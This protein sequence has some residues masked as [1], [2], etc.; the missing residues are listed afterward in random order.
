MRTMKTSLLRAAGASW[1]LT[2]CGAALG[3]GSTIA[4]L[5]PKDAAF[6]FGV[7]NFAAAKASFD[8]TGF[9]KI[10][11]DPKV[12]AFIE[13]HAKKEMEDLAKSFEDAG[14]KMDEIEAPTGPAGAAT[15]MIWNATDKR[16]DARSMAFGDWGEKADATAKQVQDAI[17]R[18]EEKKTLTVKEDEYN[19]TKIWVI[20][21][22]KQPDAAKPKGAEDGAGEPEMEDAADGMGFEGEEGHDPFEMK[23]LVYARSGNHL[24][25]ASDIQTMESTLDRLAGK[26]GDSVGDSAEFSGVMA[27]LEKPQGYAVFL[28]GPLFTLLNTLTEQA[29][30]GTEGV[31]MMLA[32]EPA[33]STAMTAFGVAG[34]KAAG[35]GI[36]FDTESAMGEQTFAVLCPE[37]KGIMTLFAGAD[38]KFTAPSFVNADSGAVTLLQF[39]FSDLLSTITESARGLPPEVGDSLVQNVQQAQVMAGPILNNLGPQVWISNSYSKPLSATSSQPLFAIAC[40]DPAQF[41][42]ALQNLGGMLPIQSRDFQGN[43]LWSLSGGLPVPGAADYAMGVGFGHVFIGSTATVENAMRQAGAPDAAGLSKEARFN[44]AVRTIGGSGLAFGYTDVRQALEYAKWT[45]DNPEKVVEA[46]MSSMFGNDPDAEAY[47][48]EMIEEAKKNQPE[49][50][51]EIP[52][53]VAARELGDTVFEFHIVPEGFKGR[54][55]WLRPTK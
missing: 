32:D 55:L 1:L 17:D 42:Q 8:K 12:K 5:A 23:S 22:V 28:T 27:Q 35:T 15:W 34:V 43:Q 6:V 36:K 4:D 13:K 45:M 29:K 38:Q 21:S 41:N 44:S 39:K 26:G 18:G 25:L 19:G 54:S 16:V 49:W 51:K 40:K 46:Q 31:D 48:K 24:I 9:R 3:A 30:A 2:L 53:D 11:D 20:D 33:V 37:K 47:K 10:W 52:L 50:M 14:V 7:D